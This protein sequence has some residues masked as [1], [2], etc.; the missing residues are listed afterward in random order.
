VKPG[1]L[2]RVKRA[3]LGLPIGAIGMI[4]ESWHMPY[5]ILHGV[6]LL[7]GRLSGKERRFIPG[8]LEVISS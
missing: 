5:T 8:D 6:K 2:V 4:M 7:T 3:R 1:N